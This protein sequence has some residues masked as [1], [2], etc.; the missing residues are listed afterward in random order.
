[1]ELFD[2]LHSIVSFYFF[3]TLAR[4]DALMPHDVVFQGGKQLLELIANPDQRNDT[5]DRMDLNGI[6]L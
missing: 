1:M 5:G 2:S 6:Q 4:H 3:V